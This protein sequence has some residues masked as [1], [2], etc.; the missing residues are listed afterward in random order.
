M[1]NVKVLHSNYADSSY[2]ATLSYSSQNAVMPVTNVL[3]GVRRTKVWRS[4]GYWEITSTNKT[5]IFQ[6]TAG[7]N[8][9]ANIAEGT[10]ASDTA[11]FAAIKTA[12]DTIA[13]GPTFTVARDTTGKIRLTSNGAGGTLFRLMCTDAGFTAATT[14]GYS[15]AADLT[16]ALFYSAAARVSHT[17]EFIKIDLGSSASVKAFLMTGLR[18]TPLKI[19]QNAVVKIMG[20]HTDTWGSPAF[21]QTLDYN[22]NAMGVVSSSGLATCRYWMLE[23]KDPYN[24]NGYV[25][26]SN[27]YLGDMVSFTRGAVQFPLRERL[28]DLSEVS[29]GR[30]GTSYSDEIQ[31][32]GEYGFA[33]KHL[34][35]TEKETLKAFSESVGV[36]RPFFMYFDPNG[37]FSSKALS[38]VKF[39]KFKELPGY[40]L[41][42]AGSW[43]SDWQIR[44]E[45]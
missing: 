30:G 25:E 19:S 31:I 15:T 43:E 13:A 39:A 45:L 12:M 2:Y 40:E 33:W 36:S 18:N 21:S 16:G 37:V 32:T 22:A 17:R 11:F 1:S 29:F 27:I 4:S 35:V 26:I 38:M 10:Y 9:T 42:R 24:V 7:V 6:K 41:V 8:L 3:Q 5:I 44:E 14:L 23:I 28:I 20:N 34:T